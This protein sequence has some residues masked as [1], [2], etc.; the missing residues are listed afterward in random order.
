MGKTRLSLH[1]ARRYHRLYSAV[2]WLNAS[3]EITLK[4]GYAVL[5]QRIR[6]HDRPY[7]DR[8]GEG[9]E[10]M[11][12][13]QAT[14]LVREWLSQAKNKTW[15]LMLD[16]YDDPRLPGIRSSIGYDIRTYFPYS[17][18]GSILI[19]TRS[20]RITFARP[21]RLNKFSEFNQSLAVL[22]RRSGRQTQGG[23]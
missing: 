16:N 20:A 15:L 2:I 8:Q 3:N 4:V 14:Q 19:T 11:D 17:T 1:F 13:E 18:Q 9:M 23:K 22:A 10:Q 5:A 7:E 12:E 6:R 21:V